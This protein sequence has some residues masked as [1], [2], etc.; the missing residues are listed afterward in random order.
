MFLHLMKMMIQPA[1]RTFF[2]RIV[3]AWSMPSV[4]I[5][6]IWYFHQAK[7]KKDEN[8]KNPKE[9]EKQNNEEDL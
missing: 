7:T 9:L 6:K 5:K 2:L 1:A 8:D 4:Y 3:E